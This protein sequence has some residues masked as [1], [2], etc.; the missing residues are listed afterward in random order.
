METLSLENRWVL[1]TCLRAREHRID[2]F[3]YTVGLNCLIR[4]FIQFVSA[5]V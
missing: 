3:F 2:Q 4:T 1:N 5:K